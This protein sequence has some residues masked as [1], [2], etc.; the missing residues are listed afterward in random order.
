M[1]LLD[2]AHN[3]AGAWTLR[4]RAVPD[5]LGLAADA[6]FQLPAYKNVEE[7]TQM[8]FPFFD[9]TSGEVEREGD[10]IIVAAID[11]P[12]AAPVEDLLAAAQR[13]NIPAH[14]APHLTA[15]FAQACEI[16]PAGGLIVATGSTYVVGDVLRLVQER[17]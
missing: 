2:V 6:D 10:H 11:S 5:A 14:A 12:R 1:L 4:A 13:L 15:A 17:V 8:L 3:P 9:S 16:T 7:M